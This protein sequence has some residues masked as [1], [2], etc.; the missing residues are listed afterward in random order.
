MPYTAEKIKLN[1]KKLTL[2]ILNK[3]PVIS[4]AKV[5]PPLVTI[6]EA[7]ANDRLCIPISIL[8]I[9]DG[10]NPLETKAM[11]PSRVMAAIFLLFNIGF[12]SFVF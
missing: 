11:V 10:R 6:S 1:G 5:A 7:S 4:E 2:K 8:S 12:A 3:R 9:G